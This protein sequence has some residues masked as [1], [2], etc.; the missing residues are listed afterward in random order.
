MAFDKDSPVRTAVTD[1]A[2]AVGKQKPTGDVVDQLVLPGVERISEGEK[3]QILTI[4]DIRQLPLVPFDGAISCTDKR[5]LNLLKDNSDLLGVR[6]VKLS[7]FPGAIYTAEFEQFFWDSD[8]ASYTELVAE[9]VTQGRIERLKSDQ[10]G[11]RQ[12]VA[13]QERTI[14]KPRTRH[15]DGFNL[16]GSEDHDGEA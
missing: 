9:M 12:K 10:A 16:V 11:S 3:I 6:L 15:F 14:D 7:D 1:E 2:R 8:S 13:R 4:T 5:L